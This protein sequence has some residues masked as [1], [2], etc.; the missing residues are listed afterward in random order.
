MELTPRLVLGVLAALLVLWALGAYNRLTRLRG[1]ILAA[2]GQ[3]DEQLKRRRDMLPAL[4][5]TLRAPLQA[6]A[7][8]LDAVLEAQTQLQAAA[9]T[10]RARP[11][12]AER[13]E[14]LLRAHNRHASALARLLALLDQ[15][16]ELRQRPDIGDWLRELHDADRRQTIARHNFNDAVQAY[17]AAL[18]QFPTRL[19]KPVFGF[20]RASRL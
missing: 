4:V 15:H 3:I 10:V 5:E 16:P 12:A 8:A 13:L 18:Q 20:R 19:L 14:A 7:P 6:E 1:V 9:D 17:N 2:W 11:L